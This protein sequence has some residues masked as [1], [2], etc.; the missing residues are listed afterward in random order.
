VVIDVTETRV[1]AERAGRAERLAGLGALAGGLAH[2][3]NNPLAALLGSVRYAAEEIE[4]RADE[5]LA[6]IGEALREAEQ[7]GRR[8]AAIVKDLESFATHGEAGGLHDLREVLQQALR[9]SAPDIEAR[10]RLDIDLREV[11]LVAGD[12]G[13][14]RQMLLHLLRNA[15]QAIPDGHPADHRIAVRCAT[16]P[17]GRAL[18]EISDDGRGMTAL[19]QRHA[20]E[21]F[22]G[23]RPDGD[24]QGLGLSVC[25][26]IVT[27]MGGAIDLVTAEGRGCTVRVWLP[28]ATAAATRT[29]A[30]TLRLVEPA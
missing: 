16:D 10:A 8:I 29:P 21:P 5:H 14:L 15:W 28:A 6:E 2:R 11:P 26:G 3:V 1:L 27:S 19:M 12:R 13:D 25:W 17:S 4:A 23:M 22:F 18:V 24:G 30:P 20:F 9:I 7:D